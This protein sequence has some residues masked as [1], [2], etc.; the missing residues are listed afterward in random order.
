[1]QYVFFL[2]FLMESL[3][4]KGKWISLGGEEGTPPVVKVMESTIDET[5]IQY[6]LKGYFEEEISI[7]GK[8]YVKIWIPEAFPILERGMPD[9]P[10]IV[11]SI[12]IP[13][14]ALM[15]YDIILDETLESKT[16]PVAPSKGHFTRNKNPDDIPFIFSTFYDGEGY[17]PERVFLLSEPYILRDLRGISLHFMPIQY[18]PSL[19][20]L[21]IHKKFVV[22]LKE[23]G[24][25]KRNIKIRKNNKISK[26]FLGIYRS[27]F[28]NFE[29]VD[30]KYNLI[31]E[32]GRLLV[33]TYSSF[34]NG[35][36]PFVEWKKQ[37]GIPTKLALY[38]DSTGSGANSIKNYI[39]NEYNSPEGVTY[40]VLVGDVNQV[41]TLYGVYEGAPSDPCYVKLEGSDHYPDA[42]ISR[43]SA[44]TLSQVEYQVNKFITYEKYP[45]AGASWYHMGTGIA[46]NEGSPPDWQRAE[47][48]RDSLLNYT[49]THIDQIYD[50]GATASQVFSA[51]NDGRSIL[52]YIGHGSGTSWGTT[53]FSNSD[54]YNLSNGYRLPFII[55]VACLNGDFTM[56]EC[57][58]EAWL[59]A[60]STSDPKGAIG[61]YASSTLASWV[62]PCIMQMEAIHLLVS[63]IRNSFGGLAF[64][65]V[66]KAMD[67]YAGTGEDIK[68]MEQ[69]NLFGDCSGIIRTD[70]PS[71]LTVYHSPTISVGQT[72][73]DV[74]VPGVENAL[75]SLYGDGILYGY[76]YTDNTGN[77]TI[78]LTVVPDSPGLLTLTVTGYNKIPYITDINVISPT[79]PFLVY[80]S[81]ILD[82]SIGGNGDGEMNPGET[83]GLKVEVA[84]VGMDEGVGIMGILLS[85]DPYINILDSLVY[86]GNIP[87]GDTVISSDDFVF[88]ISQSCP[89]GHIINFSLTLKD[90]GSGEW[91]SSFNDMVMAPILVYIT[92]VINDSSGGNGN[93]SIE[94]SETVDL[95][96]TVKNEGLGDATSVIGTISSQDPYISIIVNS[97][98]F[99]DIPDSGY[100]TSEPFTIYVDPSAP[101]PH[102]AQI[103]LSLMASGGYSWEDSFNILIGYTGF[104]D[105]ME[106]GVGE[107]VHYIITP[108]YN[109]EWHLSTLRFHSS[110]HSWK[111][112]S[113]S[114][115][116]SNYMD[117]GLETPEFPLEPNSEL[118]F[119]Y[120]MEAETSSYYTGYAYDGGVVEISIDGG[121]WEIIS[122]VDGY[123][124][125]IRGGYGN[126][127]PDETPCFSGYRNWTEVRF[128]LSGYSG[129]AKIR[130]RFTSDQGISKEGWYID[131]V[132]VRQL[133]EPDIEIEPYQFDLTLYLNEQVV[134]TLTIYN[135]GSDTL[136]FDILPSSSPLRNL[137]KISKNRS[138]WLTVYPSSGSLSPETNMDIY[139][140]IDPSGLD[141]GGYEGGLAIYNNDPDEPLILVPVYLNVV[142]CI[143][144]DV[145]GDGMLLPADLSYLANY[146][147][148]SGPAPTPCGDVN[149]DCEIN[150]ADLSYL[151][152]HLFFGGSPPVLPCST[153]KSGEDKD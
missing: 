74:Y 43:I 143:P 106:G 36:I 40:I 45:D 37:K 48:L 80:T 115:S 139:L 81:H 52:N 109:D 26:E 63:E 126:P 64:N 5:I 85:Q 69:Y 65:G 94:P 70:T 92:H 18:N 91:N 123:P 54:V 79:G 140:S 99:P 124:F 129:M 97:A 67:V 33:I 2:L 24:K 117:A 16:K 111:C 103:N 22:K 72:T 68:I 148:F 61:M 82:D 53:G 101:T 62:P 46:S 121:E 29:W 87:A 152:S 10:K 113:I 78:N 39:Q 41:P 108:G 137:I 11:E 83:M 23:I 136:T 88:S 153:I 15:G 12:V 28:I 1:M 110:D 60:G 107:W 142:T 119:W 55:D 35:I 105:D 96:T 51:L 147:F 128:N 49:Y 27:H 13:D 73:F 131:D 32:P 118:V 122:P 127:L 145:N 132:M 75:C 19:G 90:T 30:S 58:A 56:G 4:P 50:P 14:D 135:L 144:G 20:I 120:W 8:T 141:E 66:M 38:P 57:F 25:D 7:G 104:S 84:N 76:G 31:P 89:N 146:L 95:R 44:T 138:E 42:L 133:P 34:L 86:F 59:M 98:N 151:A 150:P 102:F 134:E 116:Y 112:G 21:R 47:W 77:V 6:E 17:Y 100:A 9:L 114:G 125:R 149:G 3:S 71:E 130:F 93:G